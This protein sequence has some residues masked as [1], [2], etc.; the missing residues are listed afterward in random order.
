MGRSSRAAR[1]LAL[2]REA[3]RVKAP[4]IVWT[5]LIEP[6]PPTRLSPLRAAE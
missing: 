1:D 5:D 4:E 2:A 3:K 6:A